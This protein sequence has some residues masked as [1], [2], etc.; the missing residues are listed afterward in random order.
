MFYCRTTSASTAPGNFRRMYCP[1]NCASSCSPCQPLLRAFFG[2]IQ[3]LTPHTLSPWFGQT[4]HPLL[5]SY[6]FSSPG[7]SDTEVY[8]P[9]TPARLGTAGYLCEVVVLK[10]RTNP[11]PSIRRKPRGPTQT[12]SSL[13][14]RR[15]APTRQETPLQGVAAF[16]P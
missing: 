14:Q 15:R 4:P 13:P 16:L 7:L 2:W 11:A 3:T 1:K 12:P 9:S 5:P 10:F 6:L 8:E